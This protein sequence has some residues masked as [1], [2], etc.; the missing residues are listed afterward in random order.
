MTGKP[1]TL[2]KVSIGF[3]VY[4]GEKY[5]RGAL[6]SL[7]AQ[8]FTDFELI[9]SDNAS[10]DTTEAICLEYA[11]QDPRIRYLRQSENCGLAANFQLVLDAAK[12]EYFM[13]AAADDRWDSGWLAALVEHLGPGVALAFGS[14]MSFLEDGTTQKR[15]IFKS[16]KGPRT[17]RMLRYYLQ[18]EWTPKSDV[19]YGLYRTGQIR[20][21]VAEVF[22]E[23]DDN[24]F[25]F[26]NMLVFSVLRFGCLH[27]EPGVTLYK[28]SKVGVTPFRPGKLLTWRRAAE[29]AVYLS[30]LDLVPYLFEYARRAPP[31]LTRC[32]V[33]AT[34]PVKYIFLFCGGL[35]PA[36]S[37]VARRIRQKRPVP[38]RT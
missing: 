7:L 25:G 27:I 12:C 28:R 20:E 37:V 6:D 16:L 8:T 5:V 17:P 3:P 9:I 14:S 15:S 33:L 24:R 35:V 4:N 29:F 38:A 23:G 1:T 36:A 18:S 13:W 22:G 26:D 30:K 21:V 34:M 11:S 32:A 19:I 2:P 10:T 31:G